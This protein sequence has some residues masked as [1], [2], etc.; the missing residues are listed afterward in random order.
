[1]S[2][3]LDP[4]VPPVRDDA[5]ALHWVAIYAEAAELDPDRARAWVH[6]RAAGEAGDVEPDDPGWA[7]RLRRMADATG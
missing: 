3:L 6:V 2:A 4:L 1:V 7:A 5:T